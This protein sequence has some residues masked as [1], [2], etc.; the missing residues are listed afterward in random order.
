MTPEQRLTAAAIIMRDALDQVDIEARRLAIERRRR[1]A[2]PRGQR[3]PPPVKA[4]LLTTA[5]AAAALGLSEQTLRNWRSA[6]EGPPAVTRGKLVRYRQDDLEAWADAEFT[7]D[8][9]PAQS[10][11]SP[12]TSHTVALTSNVRST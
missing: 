1:E 10:A 11:E 5:A 12:Q 9:V 3:T 7:V 2:R 8:R 6:G 4:I